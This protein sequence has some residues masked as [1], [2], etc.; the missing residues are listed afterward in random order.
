MKP[1]NLARF[2]WFSLGVVSAFTANQVLAAGYDPNVYNNLMKTRDALLQQRDY[3]QKAY[4][5]TNKQ[6]DA[7]Q[8]KMTRINNYLD[9]NDKNLRDIDQAL[10]QFQ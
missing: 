9:Q 6:I 1:R 4:D 7:L 2:G 10:R 8:Q 5:D 3:L